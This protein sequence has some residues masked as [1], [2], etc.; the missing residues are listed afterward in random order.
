MSLS[1]ELVGAGGGGGAYRVG[2]G[3]GGGVGP[4]GGGVVVVDVGDG[5]NGPGV[6]VGAELPCN[7]FSRYSTRTNRASYSA[8]GT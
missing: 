4:G 8:M 2:P 6:D 3:V 5:V 1:V 7:I